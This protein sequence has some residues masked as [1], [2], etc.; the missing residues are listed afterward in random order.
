[1]ANWKAETATQSD[2]R[3]IW[4]S[5]KVRVTGQNSYPLRFAT[6][7]DPTGQS[8]SLGEYKVSRSGC[9]LVVSLIGEMPDL[10]GDQLSRVT[11]IG[12]IDVANFPPRETTYNAETATQHV[13]KAHVALRQETALI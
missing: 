11:W 12:E 10:T 6:F 4:P 3:E 7:P 8:L 5:R 1:M 2:C 9:Q 13:L